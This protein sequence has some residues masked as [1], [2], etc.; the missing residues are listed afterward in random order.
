MKKPFY[1][2]EGLLLMLA[3]LSIFFQPLSILCVII[4]IMKIH[5][6]KKMEKQLEETTNNKIKDAQN[7]LNELDNKILDKQAEDNSLNLKLETI[8]SKLKDTNMI[9]N[10]KED[11]I[12]QYE[13]QFNIMQNFKSYKDLEKELTT[14]EVGVFK[15]QYDFEISEE[16][17]VKL[18]EI[19]KKQADYIKNGNAIIINLSEFIE[20]LELNKSTRNKFVNSISK[21][22]LRAFNNECDAALS[23]IN[24]NNITN[25]RKRIESSFNQINKLSSLFAVSIHSDYLKL[26]IEE[27]QLAF[28]YEVKKQ[29]EKEE[30]KALKEHMREEA[31]VLKE[32]EIAK[33]KIEKEETH[34]TNAL[35]DVK[36]KLK[37][38]N[39][40]EKENLLK[41]LEELENKIKE[42][43]E[44]KK[45]ILNREQNT[46]AGY[47]YIISNIGS[48]GENVYKIGMTRRLNPIERISELSSASVPFSFDVH[49]MIFSEDA[50]TLE[51]S[52]H[53]IFEKYSVNKINLRKEF[54][55]LPLDKI[56]HEVKKNHNA[57][58]KFTKLAKAE[59]YRQ[60]LKLEQSEEVESA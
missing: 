46:R 19:Q 17:G 7:K 52:L 35:A 55:R 42:I 21:L 8:Q 44:N 3:I 39:D 50:P 45:D 18:K 20:T 25:I 41:K 57:V 2:E 40:T 6:N 26:K 47:V 30:Q 59:E 24:S 58:V 14:Y 43:E 11:K 60:T 51:N 56:E 34:F 54:F 48:F 16:Y 12:K 36:N 28:E 33:K 27:L 29:E 49:A 22:V 5:Y 10:K 53:K 32:I 13:E 23:K 31:K 1:T 9:I 4:I 37:N 38:A 15:K